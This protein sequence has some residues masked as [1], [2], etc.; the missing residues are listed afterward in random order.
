MSEFRKHK[1]FCKNCGKFVSV[2][3]TY[4]DID[5][6]SKTKIVHVRCTDCLSELMNI[7]DVTCEGDGNDS[8]L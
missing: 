3:Y 1:E 4:S 5:S 8:I 6:A 7:S 2:F